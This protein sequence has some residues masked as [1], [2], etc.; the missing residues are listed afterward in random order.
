MAKIFKY[1]ILRP[2][3]FE[4]SFTSIIFLGLCIQDGVSH[5]GESCILSVF[6]RGSNVHCERGICRCKADYPIQVDSH[7]CKQGKK[8]GERCEYT[9]ECTYYDDNA[10]CTQ[11]PYRSTCECHTDYIYDASKGLCVKISETR[12]ESSNLV[13]PTA[14]GL[15]LAFASVVC[16]CLALVHMCRRQNSEGSG[17][18]WFQG[19]RTNVAQTEEQ[20]NTQ[21]RAVDSL[22]SY[23][24]VVHVENA[25]EEPPPSY[26]EAV[27]VMPITAVTVSNSDK[28]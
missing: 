22:P 26:E 14:V 16:C 6:C 24:T 4:Y 12:N 19:N 27:K 2:F 15:S 10:Y 8:Q 17:I 23:D 25:P 3:I 7:K 21:L 20:H 18:L 5:V 28:P 11:L 1:W 9:E 13:L